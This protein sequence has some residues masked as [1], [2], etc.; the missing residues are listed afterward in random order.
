MASNNNDS[1]TPDRRCERCGKDDQKLLK[2][3]RCKEAHY[4]SRK[5]QQEAWPGH[6]HT[7]RAPRKD[8]ATADDYD[9]ATPPWATVSNATEFAR[10]LSRGELLPENFKNATRGVPMA[11]LMAVLDS[12][13]N[14]QSEAYKRFALAVPMFSGRE[15][16]EVVGL[17]RK[18]CVFHAFETNGTLDRAT[19]WLLRE[20]KWAIKPSFKRKLFGLLDVDGGGGG[21]RTDE[22]LRKLCLLAESIMYKRS[23]PP[24]HSSTVTHTHRDG[25]TTQCVFISFA[26]GQQGLWFDVTLS[27][28]PASQDTLTPLPRSA[29]PRICANCGKAGERHCNQCGLRYCSRECQRAHWKAGH[30]RT[31]KKA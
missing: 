26:K 1:S 3:G 28:H 6:K 18:T 31:C 29:P 25:Q 5:C 17:C 24:G 9:T 14:I 8:A 21:D 16:D 10:A 13:G 15:V 4:C 2:C 27:E 22:E 12:L 7:C 19:R 30:K 23:K 11:W 20:A